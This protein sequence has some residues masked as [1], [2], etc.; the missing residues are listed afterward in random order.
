MASCHALQRLLGTCATNYILA[1]STILN[2][3]CHNQFWPANCSMALRSGR[4]GNGCYTVVPCSHTCSHTASSC[5]RAALQV[6]QSKVH[7]D[8][9]SPSVKF[10]SIDLLTRGAFLPFV[11][12]YCTTTHPATGATRPIL[13]QVQHDDPSA[14]L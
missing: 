14:V 9:I 4:S 10:H 1:T 3:E 11:S 12:Q 5:V 2:K 8:S 7:R 13:Q 6:K